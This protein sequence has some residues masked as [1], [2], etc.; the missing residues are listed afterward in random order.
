MVALGTG[1]ERTADLVMF[2]KPPEKRGGIGISHSA[3]EIRKS[4][5]V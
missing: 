2:Q 3:Y 4:K 5:I 1:V